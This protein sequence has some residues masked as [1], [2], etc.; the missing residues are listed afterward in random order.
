M[1]VSAARRRMA[2]GLAAVALAACGIKT[3]ATAV[4][5]PISLRAVCADAVEIFDRADM[6]GADYREVALLESTGNVV[7]TTDAELKKSMQKKAGELGAN[8]IIV[9][10]MYN[11]KNTLKLMGAALGS[12]DADRK[13][14][15]VAIYQPGEMARVNRTCNN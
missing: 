10:A 12:G 3:K 1:T 13:G 8:G 7:W 14:K 6:I 4:N 11:T 5:E 9:D 15:A 2:L